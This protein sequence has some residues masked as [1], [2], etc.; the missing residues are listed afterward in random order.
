MP[1]VLTVHHGGRAERLVEVLIELLSLS[2]D[3][4]FT[5]E[6]VAVPSRGVER[7]VVQQLARRLGA[8]S[9]D[10]IRQDGIAANIDFPFPRQLVSRAIGVVERSDPWQVGALT[11]SVLQ[12]RRQAAPSTTYLQARQIA[13]LFDRYAVYRPGLLHQW[14]AGHDHGPD[15][16][17]L[18]VDQ[19]WQAE[20]WRDLVARHGTDPAARLRDGVEQLR[21]DPSVSDLPDRVVMFAL[22]ALPPAELEVLDALGVGRDVHVLLLHPSPGWWRTSPTASLPDHLPAPRGPVLAEHPLLRTWGQVAQESRVVV[23]VGTAA[24]LHHPV[25][26]ER[27]DPPPTNVLARLQ[28]DLRVDAD[29]ARLSPLA[30]TR[31]DRSVQVHSCH[32]RARQVEVLRDAIAH[33]L[34]DASAGLELRDIVVLCPDLDGFRSLITSTLGRL[35]GVD[36]S[37]APRFPLTIAHSGSTEQPMVEALHAVIDT[38][39]GRCTA[40]AL[41]ALAAL[42]PVQRTFGFSDAELADVSS[43]VHEANV[44]WGLDRSHLSSEGIPA[45]V[46][47]TTW[48]AALDR[49]LLGVAMRSSATRIAVGERRPCEAIQLDD[50]P[51]I[52]RLAEL[53]HRVRRARAALSGSKPASEWLTTLR[54]LAA[55]FLTPDPTQPWE[56]RR[57]ARM[58]DAIESDLTAGSAGDDPLISPDEISAVLRSVDRTRGPSANWGSGAITVCDLADLRGVPHEVVCILGLDDDVLRRTT[59]HPDDLLVKDPCAGDRDVRS[60]QRAML[61][62][63]VLAARR[64]LIVTY[65]GHDVRT[66]QLMPPATPLAELLDVIDRCSTAASGATTSDLVTRHPRQSFSER[67]LLPGELGIPTPWSF[68]RAAHEGALARRHGGTARRT[69]RDVRLD[70]TVERSEPVQLADVVSALSNP[71]RCFLE[72][73][74]G[75]RLPRRTEQRDDLVVTAPDGLG[76]WALAQQLFEL[77]CSDELFP[78]EA[79][80]RWVRNATVDGHL[81][82]GRFA[83]EA[84]SQARGRVSQIEAGLAADGLPLRGSGSMP[85]DLVLPGGRRLLG[86]VADLEGDV[87]LV[88]RPGGVRAKELIDAHVRVLALRAAGVDARGVVA[89]VATS[90]RREF[91]RVNVD[92]SLDS[93]AAL[94]ALARIVALSELCRVVALPIP[95]RLAAA[96]AMKRGSIP[97]G[98]KWDMADEPTRFVFGDL[99]ADEIAA[100]VAPG[101]AESGRR[102]AERMWATLQGRAA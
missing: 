52:G 32:G 13:D 80:E 43:W 81:P 46:E 22:G 92:I 19:R 99:S 6:V 14:R 5:P 78:D 94:E 54:D 90:G 63:A 55:A 27:D 66:N 45:E 101:T 2:P 42:G 48:E 64:H 85:V 82:P 70:S 31:D 8:G 87:V 47:V 62:D 21:R 60:E 15:G 34:S 23:H 39:R 93:H 25:D 73:G 98:F 35:P 68:D 57:L 61:L 18:G 86:T 69:A 91:E 29:P 58:F 38:A 16:R 30:W 76:R 24:A 96:W 84:E 88:A 97:E 95:P 77:R 51:G 49:L 53:V 28:H 12:H 72:Q 17:P 59:S 36:E 83:V 40:T 10:G 75:V 71:V 41:G 1:S 20:L 9:H 26:D 44:R 74:L 37:G 3:D 11:W 67:N 4:P 33:L 50:A 65:T 79:A 7:W 100:Y 89:G 102:L 56:Q